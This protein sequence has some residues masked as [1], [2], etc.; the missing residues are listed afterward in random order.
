MAAEGKTETQYEHKN[1]GNLF[2]YGSTVKLDAPK[3]EDRYWDKLGRPSAIPLGKGVA[4]EQGKNSLQSPIGSIQAAS[5]VVE[6]SL[7]SSN[8]ETVTVNINN[9]EYEEFLAHRSTQ[10]SASI[11]MIDSAMS[12]DTA[13]H[14]TGLANWED[15]W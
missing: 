13:P 12:V 15:D 10:S 9:S 5:S 6:G 4:S 1:T 8:P 14:D 3:L 11:V 7:P 2:S